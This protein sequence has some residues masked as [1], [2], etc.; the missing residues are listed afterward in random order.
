MHSNH[1]YRSR[2][3]SLAANQVDKLFVQ[4]FGRLKM[5]HEPSNKNLRGNVRRRTKSKAKNKV[6]IIIIGDE[7][8]Y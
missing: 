8:I 2:L 1:C 6:K 5:R 7:K 4:S 3:Q